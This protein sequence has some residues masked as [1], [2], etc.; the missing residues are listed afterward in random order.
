MLEDPD[1]YSGEILDIDYF[2]RKLI[3][4]S[5]EMKLEVTLVKE[6]SSSSKMA[7]LEVILGLGKILKITGFLDSFKVAVGENDS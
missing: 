3:K 4:V 5:V 1:D 6:S 7:K 2:P